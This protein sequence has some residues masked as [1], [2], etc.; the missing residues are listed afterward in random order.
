MFRI[1]DHLATVLGKVGDGFADH[2]LVLLHGGAQDFSDM[3]L[4]AFTKNRHH[5]RLRLQQKFHLWILVHRG[6]RTSRGAEGSELRMLEL[7][8]FSGLEKLHIFRVRA[9]PTA[10]DV[11]HTE[12]VEALR[13]AQLVETGEL[14]AL[15]L[16]AVAQGSVVDVN[17]FHVAIAGSAD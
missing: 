17:R 10:L 5:R 14:E 3:H 15:A 1:V 13:N 16:S 12:L 2:R 7:E 6:I 4:P 9:R 8:G 11:I